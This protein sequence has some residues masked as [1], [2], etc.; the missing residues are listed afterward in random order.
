MQLRQ[1][2]R[3]YHSSRRRL[4]D[5]RWTFE[6]LEPRVV[7]AG[8][9]VINEIM[10]HPASDND[11]EE[12]IELHNTS[13]SDVDVTGWRL[14]DGVAFVF[15]EQSI[16]ASGYLVVTANA[17]A[18]AAKYPSVSNFVAGWTGT[19]ANGGER[20][21]LRDA[22]GQLVDQLVYSDEGQ[23]A[24]RERGPLDFEH[25]GWIWSD[26][27]DG[28]GRSLELVSQSLSND[29]GQN[30]SA[31]SVEQGTPGVANSVLDIDGNPAPL[32]LDVTH[33][34]AIPRSSDA[35]TI[36][37]R[38]VD[39]TPAGVQ[40]LVAYRIDGGSRLFRSVPLHDDGQG[41][42]TVAG[43]GM[44]AAVI[45]PQA[46]QAIVEWYLVANDAE[47]NQRAWPASSLPSGLQET[48]LLYQVDDSFHLDAEIAGDF[49]SYRIVMKE[50][51]RAELQQIGSNPTEA[52]SH[53]Q[54]NATFISL[55]DGQ[56]E[57][58]YN[59]GVRNRG[60][61][62]RSRLPNSYRVNIPS[63]QEWQGVTAF[64]LNTQHTHLQLLGLELYRAAGLVT[65]D[66]MPIRLQVN[67]RNLASA[68]APSYGIYAQIEAPGNEFVENHFSEDA[69][70]NLYRVARDGSSDSRGEF[71]FLGD[72]ASLYAE[73]YEKKTNE[74]END[75]SDILK[76]IDVLNSLD[77]N[78]ARRV[79]TVVDIEQWIGYLATTAILASRETALG[80]GYGDDFFLYAGESNPL[81]RVIPH[82]LDAILGQG[83]SSNEPTDEIYKATRIEAMRRFLTHPE[84]APR[85]HAKL[86]DLLDSTFAPAAFEST[87]RHTLQDIVS[88][89]KMIELM[90]FM[91][92]RRAFIQAELSRSITV[93]TG[94]QELGGIPWT[95]DPTTGIAGTAPLG[96]TRSVLV[97]GHAADFDPFSG[98]W[99]LG[100]VSGVNTRELV[101]AGSSWQYLDAGREPE[102][103]LDWRVENPDWGNSG[104]APLGY[105][106]NETTTINFVDTDLNADGIQKNIT[107]YFRRTFQV[108]QAYEL[109]GL[110]L[111]LRRDDGAIVYLNGQEIIRDNLPAG[112]ITSTTRA[113]STVDGSG[114]EEFTPWT[115]DSR[116]L[117]EGENVIAVE[118]HQRSSSSSDI[119]FDLRLE[120]TTPHDVGT[121]EGVSLR[122]GIHPLRIEAYDGL[123]GEGSVVDSLVYDIWYD[124]GF[125]P[126]TIGGEIR[127]DLVLSKDAGPYLVTEDL[128]VVD[129]SLTIEPGTTVFF[130]LGTGLT[131]SENGR[132]HAVGRPDDRIRLMHNPAGGSRNWNGLTIVNT[133]SDNRFEYIDFRA[134]D[135]KGNAVFVDHGRAVFD[136]A[137]WFGI[138]DQVIDM[139]HPTLIVRNSEIPSIS[140]D[141]TIH[142]VGFDEGDQLI[143][144]GNTIG[145]N[146]SGNDVIDMGPDSTSRGTI[147]F[148]NNTFLGGLDD[149]VDTDGMRVVFENNTFIDFHLQSSRATTSNAISTG[150]QD[151]GAVTMSSELEIRGNTFY[152]V[153]HALLLKDFSYAKFTNNT[154]VKATVGGLQFQE[155]S[156]SGVIGPGR[157]A[158]IDGNIF[159]ETPRIL[160]A[161]HPDTEYTLRRSLVTP[162]LV[163][164]GYG[165]M[166]VNP[167][168]VDATFALAA[169]SPARNAG[170]F[171]SN[172]GADQSEVLPSASAANL[173]V[174][175]LHYH[176]LAGSE[177]APDYEVPAAGEQFEFIELWN[178]SSNAVD[179]SGVRFTDGINYSFDAGATIGPGERL[180]VVK[181]E[182]AFE[183]RY[184]QG[185]RVVG[186]FAGQ[187]SNGGETVTLMSANGSE[188]TRF[189]YRD[190]RVPG[191]PET[192]DGDGYSL[193][194]LTSATD[195]NLASSWKASA[196]HGGT[197][198][199]QSLGLYVAETGFRYETDLTVS[200]AFSE[201]IN[202]ASLDAEDFVLTN[203]TTG[204]RLA[205]DKLHFTLRD[206]QFL[207]VTLALGK[208]EA[209]G[210]WRLS[211]APG[212]IESFTGQPM[213]TSYAFEFFYLAG[214]YNRDRSVD[215]ADFTIWR[216]ARGT[217][218]LRANGDRDGDSAESIDFAD[219]LV[220]SRNFGKSLI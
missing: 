18:F 5:A 15:P 189:T 94:L 51:E 138:N 47:D 2:F 35:V 10:Y 184:G 30:W 213:T 129:G 1:W 175:E 19:L 199:I 44:Y 149:G 162:E 74:G 67:G 58:R 66:G 211:I 142:L 70:G 132:I 195:L 77:A 62:S 25:R 124:N 135:G 153:D 61:S 173:H 107:S 39:D 140:G 168:F 183:S 86:L 190:S 42:D 215:A 128:H 56:I 3:R 191:W 82:D 146:W 157:G 40:G 201:L 20:I 219:F 7:L 121:G 52:N 34:P 155:L 97:D 76:L 99:S 85:Y 169:S 134:G 109:T 198:A 145:K 73:N 212:S 98:E 204:E 93:Q 54:M 171:G 159:W 208:F 197:P 125:V 4:H 12:Y 176:P 122:P 36:R 101:A 63:D 185:R 55:T 69:G 202:I 156:G 60:R 220:L 216:D 203:L 113:E 23:W 205:S 131:V 68:D 164:R 16:P 151:I 120:G 59:V 210:Q 65:E 90:D 80:T 89:D 144:E 41:A 32:I 91:D 78:Y 13:T 117:E 148:R 182:A 43:D 9:V 160:E 139:E 79:G 28:N 103:N 95:T 106:D 81:F 179:L 177:A 209:D 118:I 217:T 158:D 114:E 96:R 102:E 127:E 200:L 100:A 188:I 136:S 163:E 161:L 33:S 123:N 37:A 108:E 196:E 126:P 178:S 174:T 207:D 130:D 88:E 83:E 165:N 167:E 115:I 17:E 194:A 45:P 141:E 180:V 170:P 84:I 150:H 143:F 38:L 105:G 72:D 111:F 116:L 49:P 133:Q 6:T 154:V 112:D 22:A 8:H 11:A 186:E 29:Y 193:V 75:Y 27:H 119:V 218:D 71:R 46:D 48:N 206:T 192:A 110:T 104:S 31:S 187:L 181:N 57:T 214:D 92:A 152:D 137:S 50:A 166:S 172:M 64:N 24:R 26:A 87:V 53:A 147:Y 21:R 14:D